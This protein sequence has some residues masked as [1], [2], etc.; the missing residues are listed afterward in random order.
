MLSILYGS[1][2]QEIPLRDHFPIIFFDS[3]LKLFLT[4]QIDLTKN[5]LPLCL[6]F[7]FIS[8]KVPI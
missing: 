1:Q 2:T 4:I 7:R 6:L 8:V 3:Q 5:R